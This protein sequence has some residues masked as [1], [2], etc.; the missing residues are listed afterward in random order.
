[1]GLGLEYPLLKKT[2]TQGAKIV[3]TSLI[4]EVIVTIA[5]TPFIISALNNTKYQSAETISLISLVMLMS[6]SLDLL[7]A[8]HYWAFLLQEPCS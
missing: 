4:I 3:G 5:A 8:T 6:I 2:S 7:H 1:V